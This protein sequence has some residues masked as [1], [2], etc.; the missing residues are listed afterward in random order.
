MTSP[1]A[2][3]GTRIQ[4]WEQARDVVTGKEAPGERGMNSLVMVTGPDDNCVDSRLGLEPGAA[5]ITMTA[6]PVSAVPTL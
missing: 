6:G 4:G 5:I 2:T 3:D 1:A